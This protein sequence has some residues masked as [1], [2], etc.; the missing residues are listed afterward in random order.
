MGPH[1]V[2]RGRALEARQGQL[3]TEG[4]EEIEVPAGKFK[5]HWTQVE[6]DKPVQSVSKTWTNKDV[7]GSMV[8]ME[9]EAAGTKTTMIL[10]KLEKK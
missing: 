10:T 7:P 8:K 4:D 6:M 9:S 1:A 2:L 5:C 3:R